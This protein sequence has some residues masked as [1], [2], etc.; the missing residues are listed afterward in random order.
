MFERHEVIEQENTFAGEEFPD[1]IAPSSLVGGYD[2]TVTC[3][4]ADDF[5][6]MSI[7]HVHQTFAI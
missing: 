6:P 7:L 5:T 2:V 4:V 3:A 1:C